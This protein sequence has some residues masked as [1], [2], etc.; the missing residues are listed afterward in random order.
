[1][2][3]NSGKTQLPTCPQQ[4]PNDTCS[5][6][7]PYEP[8]FLS[9]STLL[10]FGYPIFE[11]VM[12]QNSRLILVCPTSLVVHIYAA[13]YGV[14]LETATAQCIQSTNGSELNAKCYVKQAFD[15]IRKSCEWESRCE[16]RATVSTL[17]GPDLCPTNQKQLFLQ[18]QCVD[19]QVILK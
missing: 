8:S 3:T 13:Y 9:N 12:C 5:Q 18:Y 14:Q 4:P 19:L 2:S 15:V 6:S 1:M 17:G 16:V 10:Y 7:S 11:Q